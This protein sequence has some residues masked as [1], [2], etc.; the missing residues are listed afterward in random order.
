MVKGLPFL[1]PQTAC[2]LN[3]PSKDKRSKTDGRLWE[4]TTTK[5][6]AGRA[7]EGIGSSSAIWMS[8]LKSTHVLIGKKIE[9]FERV[10]FFL[11]PGQPLHWKAPEGVSQIWNSFPICYFFCVSPFKFP[12]MPALKKLC[13]IPIYP[14]I[15]HFIYYICTPKLRNQEGK[16]KKGD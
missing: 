5:T 16:N 11:L 14:C 4:S 8:D 10:I 12:R 6:G 15:H 2:N 7:G 1:Y 3:H 9:E 13:K